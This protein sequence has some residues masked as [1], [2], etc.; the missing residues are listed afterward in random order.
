AHEINTPVQYVGDN[1]AF[2]G[3][4]CDELIDLLRASRAALENVASTME[5]H[6]IG[7]EARDLLD[8]YQLTDVEFLAEEIPGAIRQSL[9]GARRVTK[10][11]RA[12]KEFAHPGG[13]DPEPTDINRLVEST[14]SVASNEWKYVAEVELDLQADLPL[15]ACQPAQ[16]SQVVLILMVNAA[17]AITE[18]PESSVTP[19][20]IAISTRADGAALRL[21]VA[22]TG[23]GIPDDVLPRIFEPF[24]TTKEVGV[25]SGQGLSLAN[26]IVATNHGGTL[27][28]DSQVGVGT[29]ITV[30]IPLSAAEEIAADGSVDDR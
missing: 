14:V 15:V 20:R 11:V 16:L 1:L 27:A 6:A 17:Q 5:G 19:G 4:G 12:L 29:T 10:I 2:L 30:T 21:V 7:G 8:R 18:R 24:F 9:E 23:A 13:D 3:T 28:V 26:K 25:G 22:D